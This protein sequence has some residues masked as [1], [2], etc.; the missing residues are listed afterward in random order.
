MPD[1]MLLGVDNNAGQDLTILE[2]PLQLNGLTTLGTLAVTGAN[3]GWDENPSV[4]VQAHSIGVHPQPQDAVFITTEGGTG[5]EHH[6]TGRGRL[7]G[8]G[9]GAAPGTAS[10]DP[11]GHVHRG[12]H[13]GW[14][15]HDRG[16]DRSGR[17]SGRRNSH[18]RRYQPGAHGRVDISHEHQRH[19]HR[20]Q[21]RRW[22]RRLG[23]AQNPGTQ[24]IGVVGV[25][26]VEGR[27][28][29]FSGGAAA[30]RM[31]PAAAATHPTTGEGWRLLR[32]R[33]GT[34]LVLPEGVSRRHSSGLEADRLTYHGAP[35][36][37]CPTGP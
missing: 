10:G 11:A 26:D 28:G 25:G 17:H 19:D 18:L 36:L 21:R 37:L 9:A 33:C 1:P 14:A 16:H 7:D 8:P 20:R 35:F 22:N 5:L 2:S 32:R 4:T 23:R 31:T 30:L 6:R 3:P 27:G 24:G 29:Q 13:P 12:H 15:G 34:T